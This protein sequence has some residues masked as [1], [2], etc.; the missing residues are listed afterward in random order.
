MPSP[1]TKDSP[2]PRARV[3]LV[4]RLDRAW[5]LLNDALIDR[6]FYRDQTP[7]HEEL[8]ADLVMAEAHVQD[9][10]DLIDRLETRLDA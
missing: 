3:S 1:A 6:E 4:E 5:A 9:L 8:S 7:S 2:M 10:Y